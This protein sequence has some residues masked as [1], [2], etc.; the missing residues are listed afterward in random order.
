MTVNM[1]IKEI[2]EADIAKNHEGVNA[3]QAMKIFNSYLNDGYEAKKINDTVFIYKANKD[4]VN[5][6]SINAAPMK[7]YVANVMEF[8]ETIKE[9]DVA[10]TPLTNPKLKGLIKRY[11][12]KLVH[13]EGDY[14]I[15][16]LRSI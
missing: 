2:I 9:Y 1:D 14:A 11:L 5:Y 4:T 16:D 3:E 8:F 10:V 12:P 15:T 7:D 13:I 6:H